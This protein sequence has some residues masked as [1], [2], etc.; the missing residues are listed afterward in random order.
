MKTIKLNI[1]II[2][3][4]LPVLSLSGQEFKVAAPANGRVILKN[5]SGELPVEGYKGN[6]IIISSAS[7]K[8]ETPER[9]KG[10]KPIY[11]SGT[12]N[13]GIGVS[14]E[15]EGSNVN[16]TCLLPFTRNANYSIKIPENISVEIESGCENSNH[17][18]ITNMNNEIV[19]KNC[20]DIDLKNITGPVVLSS[21]SGNI[22]VDFGSFSANKPSSINSVS[23]DIDVTIPQKAE[24]QIE[25]STINGSFYSDF[26]VKQAEKNLKRIGGSQM[27]FDLNG[28]GFKFDITTVTGNIYLR[29]GK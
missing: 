10:L 14:V 4:L 16:I 15:K 13:S 5:F 7:G 11:S 19:I 6:E 28:G 24:A 18:S 25:L 1:L 23:G 9:A 2:L 12:D 26:E 20:H 21:I 8:A 22:N 3:I 17:I 29:K 27:S